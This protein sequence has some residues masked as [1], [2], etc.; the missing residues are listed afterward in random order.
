MMFI[1]LGILNTFLT[2]CSQLTMGFSECNPTV[3]QGTSENQANYKQMK[4]CILTYIVDKTD[5]K[6]FE[7]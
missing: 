3:S 4:A 7:E 1:M 5:F 2:W 6:Y